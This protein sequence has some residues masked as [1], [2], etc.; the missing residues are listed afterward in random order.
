MAVARF[1]GVDN[2]LL[3]LFGQNLVHAEAK[4]GDLN[5]VGKFDGL[6]DVL[7]FEL[8]WG[9]EFQAAFA[10]QSGSAP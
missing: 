6:H 7:S 2:G 3:G 8:G 10:F 1:D 4:Q 5:P 9:N